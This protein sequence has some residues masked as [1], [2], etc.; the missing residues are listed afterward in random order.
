MVKRWVILAIGMVCGGALYDSSAFAQEYPSRPLRLI[1]PYTAGGVYDPLMRA[2]ATALQRQLGQPVIVENRTGGDLVVGAQAVTHAPA[3]GYSMF[4]AGPSVTTWPVFNR[5]SPVDLVRDFDPVIKLLD[6]TGSGIIVSGEVPANNLREFIKYARDNPGKLNYGHA[7]RALMLATESFKHA[8]GVDMVAVP[9]K[10]IADVM[11]AI[12]GNNIQVVLNS[13]ETFLPH[14]KTGKVKLLAILA[15]ERMA[16]FPSV[17]TAEEEGLKGLAYSTWLGILVAKATPKSIIARLN[18]EW[19]SAIKSDE[20]LAVYT[21]VFHGDARL[22]PGTPEEF[23]RFLDE[24]LRRWA[25][26][27]RYAKIQPD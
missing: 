16:S 11:N 2:G 18:K 10:G 24:E 23:G 1:V 19:T 21:K 22:A 14:M 15:K 4:A 5:E 13:P 12:L 26:I 6:V 9:Y 20:F 25:D 27:A 17:P 8:A 3:D 7:S